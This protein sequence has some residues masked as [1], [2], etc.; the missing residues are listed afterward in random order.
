MQ[1]EKLTMLFKAKFKVSKQKNNSPVLL[2]N[3][4]SGRLTFKGNLFK[5]N[6]LDKKLNI[7]HDSEQGLFLIG[8]D[9]S[10]DGFHVKKDRRCD[11]T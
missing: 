1:Q 9:E 8:V 6:F 5:E 2:V 10:M 4:R 11:S 3:I 7:A